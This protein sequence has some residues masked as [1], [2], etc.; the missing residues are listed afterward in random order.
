MVQ[1]GVNVILISENKKHK[2]FVP[3]KRC[4]FSSRM[5]AERT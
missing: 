2:G 1:L 5:P 4:I 3:L